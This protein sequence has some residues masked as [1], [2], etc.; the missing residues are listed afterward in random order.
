MKKKLYRIELK[1]ADWSI[2]TD[3]AVLASLSNGGQYM[4]LYGIE[5]YAK[6]KFIASGLKDFTV[7]RTGESLLT[8]DRVKDGATEKLLTL[9]E[10]EVFDLMDEIAP[11]LHR[12]SVSNL[13]QQGEQ[14]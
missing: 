8:I 4:N 9:T 7:T 14:C 6:A 2:P 3:T 11:S 5:M 1:T 12:Q 13:S 10:V